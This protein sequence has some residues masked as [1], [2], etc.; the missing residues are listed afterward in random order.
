MKLKFLPLYLFIA[1]VSLFLTSCSDDDDAVVDITVT[2]PSTYKFERNGKSTVSFSGQ[3]SRLKMA[4][5]LY[6]GMKSSSSTKAGL[7]NM[8]NNGTGFSDATLDASGKKVGNKTFAS[9]VSSATVKPMFDAMITDF[10]DNVIPN[11]STTAADGTAGKMTDSKRTVYINAKGHE[12]TQLFTKGLIGGMT[13]DQIVNGYLSAAKLDTGTNRSDNDAGTLVSGKDYTQMEHYWDEGFGYLYGEEADVE[14]PTLGNGVLLSKYAGKVDGSNSPGIGKIIY[15]AFKMGRAA[16]VAKNYTVR[17]AQAKIIQMHI[18]KI[19]GY[20]AHDYLNDYVT[21]AAA[22]TPADA[23]HALSEG[24][25]F[26]MSLQVTNDG[27]GKPYFTNAEV[28]TMLAKIENFWTVSSADCTAMA[29][30]IKAKM[31]L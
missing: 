13:M 30:D 24:Y 27:T 11:W 5:E 20:K 31:N 14:N 28:N 3:T 7:N 9:S 26:I 12:L 4:G 15:D 21:K 16:I 22:G 17:D 23:I 29:N 18:S 2:P 8:F 10:A 19:I 1:C 25:G 6:S